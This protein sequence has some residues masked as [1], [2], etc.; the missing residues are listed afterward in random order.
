MEV[1]DVAAECCIDDNADMERLDSS[2]EATQNNVPEPKPQLAHHDEGVQIPL[3]FS[4][5]KT[6]FEIV[7]NICKKYFSSQLLAF[8]L[9]QLKL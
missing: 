4:K 7:S 3:S 1:P 2:T 9:S 5:Y 6:D 8:F